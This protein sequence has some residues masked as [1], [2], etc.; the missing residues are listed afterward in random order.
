MTFDNPLTNFTLIELTHRGN[1]GGDGPFTRVFTSGEV[2]VR[3]STEHIENNIRVD[4]T[5]N[6]SDHPILSQVL[7]HKS[8]EAV[9][10]DMPEYIPSATGKL[11]KRPCVH[12]MIDILVSPGLELH[13]FELSTLR[14]GVTFHGSLLLVIKDHLHVRAKTGS[15]DFPTADPADLNIDSRRIEIAT[16]SGSISGRYPLYDLLK[17]TSK[18]GSISVDV[19]L[20]DELKSKPLPA[21]LELSTVSG[22]VTVRNP[23]LNHSHPLHSLSGAIPP[24]DYRTNIDTVHGSVTADLV[25]NTLTS[26]QTTSGTIRTVLSPVGSPAFRSDIH[27]S[28]R[29]GA[30]NVSVQRS[31]THPDVPMRRLWGNYAYTYGSLRVAY[32]N[33]WEG[34]VEGRTMQ[35]SITVDW[36]GMHITRDERVVDGALWR[37]IE[38]YKGDGEGRLTFDGVSG[39]VHL[40]GRHHGKP[41]WEVDSGGGAGRGVA[42]MAGG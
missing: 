2:H 4:V 16:Q 10:I 14:M 38:G 9:E 42:E 34:H 25:H 37:T 41:W 18:A 27:A 39:S 36:P 32:P 15:I 5:M 8:D 1:I 40:S 33:S 29:S 26:V 28:S 19:E 20:R 30:I 3:P 31:L 24:R 12:M 17:I 6:Y 13:A 22:S 23:V 11:S 35:G 21:T 7:F